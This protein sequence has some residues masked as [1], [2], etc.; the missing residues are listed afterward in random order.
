MKVKVL[1]DYVGRNSGLLHKAG[2]IDEW[3][4]VGK[5]G[6]ALIDNGFVEVV[7]DDEEWKPR[8][9]ETY[10]TPNIDSQDSYTGL[11]FDDDAADRS[12][13]ELGLAFKTEEESDRMAEWL[14]AVKVLR[15]D[16]ERSIG[17]T[18]TIL[19]IWFVSQ[20]SDRLVTSVYEC[21]SAMDN[22]FPFSALGDAEKSIAEHVQEWLTFFKFMSK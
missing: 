6:R 12:Y 13:V 9:N 16:S 4:T 21:C 5:Y 17:C 15:R 3:S 8:L 11:C 14:K 20:R 1:K 7:E 2:T 10:F 18:K 22:P 19:P